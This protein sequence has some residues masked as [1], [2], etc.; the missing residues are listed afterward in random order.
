MIIY[1]FDYCNADGNMILGGGTANLTTSD[2]TG[3]AFLM[4]ISETG[5]VEWHNAIHN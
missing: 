5:Y 2:G 3:D 1:S 4:R